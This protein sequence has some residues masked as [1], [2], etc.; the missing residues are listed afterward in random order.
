MRSIDHDLDRCGAAPFLGHDQPLRHD[1][2]QVLRQIE[3]D[4]VVLIARKHVDDAIERFRRVIGMQGRQHQVPGAGQRDRRLHGLAIADFADEYDIRR[5]AHRA[6]QRAGVIAGVDADFA[7]VDDRTL[8]GVQEFD[9]ILDR[10]YVIRGV[11]VAVI[12]H[13]RKTRRLA[14]AGRADHQHQSAFHHHQVFHDLWQSQV[15]HAR[16]VGG[17]EAQH[18]GGI[19]TLIENIDAKAAEPGLRNGKVDFQ[20]APEIFE[21]V[22]AHQAEGHVA[23]HFSVQD[24]F[25]DRENP[26]FDLDLDGR[27][28][29]EEKIR[30]LLVRHQLQ[31]GL[32]V[33]IGRRH[34]TNARIGHAWKGFAVS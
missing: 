4:L 33:D 9:R 17:D 16:H 21:L 18:H 34:R 30:R 15:L 10:D 29:R 23:D 3:I 7:L 2:A 8:V 6:A 32:E 22:A 31:Q 12:D 11:L 1:R 5:G 26:A 25:V 13:G 28:G 19:A 27:V 20:F 14:R 24:L